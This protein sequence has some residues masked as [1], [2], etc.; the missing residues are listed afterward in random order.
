MK[1]LKK[2]GICNILF[3]II[4]AVL[5]GT[6]GVVVATNIASS[7]VLYMTVENADVATIEDALDDLYVSAKS[8]RDENDQ[9]T[10]ELTINNSLYS[11]CQTELTNHQNYIDSIKNND[12]V[13]KYWN[14]SFGHNQYLLLEAPST[15]YATRAALETAYGASNFAGKPIYIKSV[16]KGNI[17]VYHYACIYFS[18]TGKEFCMAPNYWVAGDSDGS[19]TANKLKAGI[20]SALGTTLSGSCINN[21][22]STYCYSG[23]FYF[24]V[25]PAG[26]VYIMMPSGG[27]SVEVDGTAVC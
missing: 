12:F 1:L 10:E 9:L 24:Y 21:S 19:L 8:I 14:D 7:E 22:S 20:E 6:V 23:S 26:K 5:F 13:Y 25:Y 11:E 27:C 4:G 2:I 3:F 17:A 16:F 15:V 18:T